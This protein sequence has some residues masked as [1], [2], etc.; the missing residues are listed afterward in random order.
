M[1]SSDLGEEREDVCM[2]RRGRTCAGSGEGGRKEEGEGGCARAQAVEGE[3]TGKGGHVQAVGRE[4]CTSR[5]GGRG[6]VLVSRVKEW[7]EWIYIP[8]S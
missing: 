3:G 8:E 6:N 4:W 2:Q 7:R 5:D 1:C